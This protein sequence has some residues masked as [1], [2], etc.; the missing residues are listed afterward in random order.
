MNHANKLLISAI[1]IFILFAFLPLIGDLVVTASTEP[2]TETI[3]IF[4]PYTTR[5]AILTQ[6]QYDALLDVYNGDAISLIL[7][8]D[9]IEYPLVQNYELVDPNYEFRANPNTKE[10]AEVVQTDDWLFRFTNDPMIGLKIFEFNTVQDIPYLD[11]II[12]LT[13]Y[14]STYTIILSIT[15]ETATAK[16]NN[17]IPIVAVL[18]TTSAILIYIKFR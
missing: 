8:R 7:E 12:E 16:L 4:V 10:L 18:I 14:D 5:E 13:Q 9:N 15:V 2:G 6:K 1:L 3:T 11:T 17:L